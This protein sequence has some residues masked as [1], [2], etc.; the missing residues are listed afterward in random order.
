MRIHEMVLVTVFT[1]LALAAFV[2]R[3]TVTPEACSAPSP[4]SVISLFAPCLQQQ[5]MNDPAA[6]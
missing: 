6:R 3:F 2:A 4:R 5:A 1:V